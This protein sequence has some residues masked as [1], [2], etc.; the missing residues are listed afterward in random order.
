MTFEDRLRDTMQRAG[1]SQPERPALSW[2]ATLRRARR[3]RYVRLTAVAFAAAVAIGVA[4]LAAEAVLRAGPPGGLAPAAPSDSPSVSE[5]PQESPG[6]GAPDCS[7]AGMTADLTE[8]DLPRPVADMRARIAE[9]ATHCNY[10]SLGR[11][12]LAGED[13]FTYSYGEDGR[14]GAF[15]RKLEK[16]DEDV[17]A[18]LVDVLEAPFCEEEV[19]SGGVY[20]FWPSASCSDATEEDY[21]ALVSRGL[22]TRAEVRDFRTFGSYIGYRA[23]MSSTGDWIVYVAGD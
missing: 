3:K 7:A 18:M 17:M 19:S 1:E 14:P 8:Q 9:A 20:Y 21:D 10:A 22:Y 6:A 12:A 2:D 23:G 13:F 15:W 16:R 5:P 4:T 11:L